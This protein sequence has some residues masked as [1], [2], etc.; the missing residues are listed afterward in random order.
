MLSADATSTMAAST[1]LRE[2]ITMQELK[3]KT[4]VVENVVLSAEKVLANEY[5]LLH[6]FKNLV[7]ALSA[8]ELQDHAAFCRNVKA[9][10]HQK[11]KTVETF[12]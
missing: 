8:I 9:V 3:K 12:P 6:Q 2:I 7:E 11:S 4:K 1:I 5:T 10:Q